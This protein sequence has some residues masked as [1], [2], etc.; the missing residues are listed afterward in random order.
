VKR[1]IIAAPGARGEASSR[2]RM[3]AGHVSCGGDY[4][5]GHTWEVDMVDLGGV[6]RRCSPTAGWIRC[7][8]PRNRE[9]QLLRD[10]ALVF[11]E[12]KSYLR[13]TQLFESARNVALRQGSS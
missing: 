12:L 1:L 4:S 11:Y 5:L 13:M 8:I 10:F 2:M 7:G 3:N 6:D 9:L